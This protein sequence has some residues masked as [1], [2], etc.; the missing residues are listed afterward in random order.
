[1]SLSA[2]LKQNAVKVENEKYAV[3]KRFLDDK[4]KPE[5]WEIRA[6]TSAED[7][8]IRKSC[9]KKVPVPGK[10]GQ[11]TQDVDYNAY[12]AKM[13]VACTV[14]PNLND[15][16][17]QDNYGVMGA[18]SLLKAMLL[19]GEYGDYAAKVQAICGFDQSFQDLVDEAKN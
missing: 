4:G 19:P 5:K 14:Y 8:E 7:E 2:F 1:M 9:T 18:E 16:E 17:L 15:K 6:I 13:C 10:R 12:V 11:Y 3:S